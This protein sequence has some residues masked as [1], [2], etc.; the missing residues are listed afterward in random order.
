[1]PI[2]NYIQPS[3]KASARKSHV[4][5]WLRTFAKSCT[6]STNTAPEP[7]VSKWNSFGTGKG[8]IEMALR[9][10]EL[11]RKNGA[12]TARTRTFCLE[13]AYGRI[14]SKK[15]RISRK[16]QHIDSPF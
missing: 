9:L 5:K 6:T 11:A 1:M 13:D 7:I 10:G 2:A 12:T 14:C 4:T 3:A 8:R 15:M 16:S